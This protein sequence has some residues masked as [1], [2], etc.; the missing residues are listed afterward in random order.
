MLCHAKAR[1]CC[2]RQAGSPIGMSPSTACIKTGMSAAD[3]AVS[4]REEAPAGSE[5]LL[6]PQ[7]VAVRSAPSGLRLRQTERQPVQSRAAL[8]C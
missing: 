2:L 5:P 3:Q 8:L 1:L 4:S 7:C 6:A